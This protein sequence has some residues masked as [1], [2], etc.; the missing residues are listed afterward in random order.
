[1]EVLLVLKRSKFGKDPVQNH[2]QYT[3]YVNEKR[4][5]TLIRRQVTRHDCLFCLVGD[6]SR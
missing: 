3:R 6:R 2:I 5:K 4:S 1:M